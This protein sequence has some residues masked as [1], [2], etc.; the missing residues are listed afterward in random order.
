MLIMHEDQTLGDGERPGLL[1]SHP[2]PDK[3]LVLCDLPLLYPI[4]SSAHFLPLLLRSTQ[5][6][7]P[8]GGVGWGS[9]PRICYDATSRTREKLGNG[10][11]SA[12]PALKTSAKE[13]NDNPLLETRV[14]VSFQETCHS[15]FFPA[16]ATNALVDHCGTHRSESVSRP[17][18]PR[19]SR[20][21]RH[22]PC[23]G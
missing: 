15:A 21:Q 20:T 14:T 17:L 23:T 18:T 2:H 11:K 4:G 5:E 10:A 9:F 1:T 16:D 19:G 8:G 22:L 12:P 3:A 7:V 13:V 6:G